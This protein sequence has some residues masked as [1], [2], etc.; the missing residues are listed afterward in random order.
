M[1]KYFIPEDPKKGRLLLDS[2]QCFVGEN[3]S[4]DNKLEA[5][6]VLRSRIAAYVKSPT[7][8]V[9]K[10]IA[11]YTKASDINNTTTSNPV[12]LY[13]ADYYDLGYEAAFEDRTRHLDKGKWEISTGN[14]DVVSLLTPEGKA[15]E[16]GSQ[17]ADYV[18]HKTGKYTSGIGITDENIRHSETAQIEDKMKA[19]RDAYWLK[20]S[21][22]H[23]GLL[24]ANSSETLVSD[25]TPNTT[26]QEK[27]L[28]SISAA[29]E[30]VLS[31]LIANGQNV[32][33][34]SQMV[35]YID[36]KAMDLLAPVLKTLAQPVSGSPL[37]LQRNV[38][39]VYTYDAAITGIPVDAADTYSFLMCLPGVRIQSVNELS[40]QVF[41]M[42]DIKTFTEIS[43]MLS[44]YGAAVADKNQ[45]KINGLRTPA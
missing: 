10:K 15:V 17:N 14:S 13:N 36:A 38:Q 2:L 4:H 18:T 1:I 30:A 35:M 34:F 6:K 43:T 5:G 22:G 28:N 40:P 31:G 39:V 16:I 11:A 33:P 27:W 25:N 3:V 29:V 23:Y 12:N 21:N 41:T 7:A 44:Y 45:I 9:K 8:E 24:A 26:Y 19:F 37:V 42:S 20:K 32:S